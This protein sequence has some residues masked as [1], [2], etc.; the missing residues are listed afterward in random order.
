MKAIQLLINSELPEDLRD[1]S[2]SYDTKSVSELMREV[3]KKYPEKYVDISQKLSDI[4]RNASFYQGETLTLSD[5][6]PV[7]DKDAILAKMDAEV[8]AA[9]GEALDDD[10]FKQSRLKVWIKYSDMLEKQTQKAALA[11]G[12]NLAYSVVSGARGKPPQLKAMLTTP[13]LFEDYKGNT[14][15]LFVRRSFGQGLRPYEYLASTAGTRKSVIATKSSTARGGDL[16]KIMVQATAPLVVTEKDCGV[17]NGIKLPM[18]DPSIRGRV[19]ARGAKDAETGSVLD[20]RTIADLKN[21]D[22]ASVIVRSPLTCQA[23]E[24]VCSKC[25]GRWA[26]K[27]PKIGDSVGITAAQSIGEPVTQMA[28]NTKH[29]AGM[30]S[31]KKEFSGFD[32]IS[33]FTASPETF[34][35]RASVAEEDGV[36]TKVEKA[37]QGGHYIFVND[38]SHYVLPGYDITAKPGDKVEAGDALSDGLVDPGDIVRLR[39]LGEGRNYYVNRLQKILGDSGMPADRRNVEMLAR[40]ALNHVVVEDPDGVGDYLPDDVASYS[41]LTR[42]YTPPENAKASSAADAVGRY[43]QAPALHYSIGTRITPRIGKDLAESGFDNILSSDDAPGFRPDMTNLRTASHYQDD[44]LAAQHTSYLRKQ[45]NQDATRGVDT[46]IKD[47]I[48]FA[49]RLAVGAGFGDKVETTGKF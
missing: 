18:D 33:Q 44:W 41:R 40:A 20:S 34:P 35:D 12:N 1:S 14:V 25:M 39:G 38:K 30:S 49:P 5:L 29:Q 3:A 27:F 45:L 26:G 21:Q 37:S 8:D 48:H 47:N 22:E 42:T 13:G 4:G 10:D 32:V 16:S 9:R 11:K 15:P 36:V 6:R 46:N 2:R 28:L 24:G 43:L 31:G 19:L 17:S 23:A 7:L